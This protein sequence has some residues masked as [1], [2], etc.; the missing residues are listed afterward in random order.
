MIERR[1]RRTWYEISE[2]RNSDENPLRITEMINRVRPRQ[3]TFRFS[4]SSS[5]KVTLE[6]DC[7]PTVSDYDA[8]MLLD[9][10]LEEILFT[11]A[12]YLRQSDKY[13]VADTSKLLADRSD[14]NMLIFNDS[15]RDA[16][17]LLVLEG[18]CQT[19]TTPPEL[20][21]YNSIR[22]Y[23]LENTWL[24]SLPI[25][26]SKHHIRWI[27]FG[28]EKFI[29]PD[30]RYESKLGYHSHF[31]TKSS[32]YNEQGHHIGHVNFLTS[33]ALKEDEVYSIFGPL[34][35]KPPASLAGK[36]RG[37]HWIAEI[38]SQALEQA[39][40]RGD[41]QAELV[42][43]L[44][45]SLG[46]TIFLVV[47]SDAFRSYEQEVQRKQ[48]AEA[49]SRLRLRQE[50][51]QNADKVIFKGQP[52]MV[53][54]SN[55]NEVLALLCKLDALQALPF[56]KFLLWEYTA[57]VGI[58]A[59]ASYQIKEIDAPTPFAAVEL[60]HHFENFFDHGH[61][62]HQVNLVICWDFRDGEVPSEL[63][64][65]SGW[66]E[67]IFEYRNDESFVILALARIPDIQIGR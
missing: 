5:G 19:N 32:M 36:S 27:I 24:G 40:V 9:G 13:V 50:R 12:L 33:Q 7:E 39:V 23:L 2:H 65:R 11:D 1:M 34:T 52:L 28:E 26:N 22:S 58:D 21:N 20:Q 43:G 30:S 37:V 53:A 31:A 49:A 15:D 25:V 62:P 29:H 46:R 8:L 17:A 54:P 59:I 35:L 63:R 41:P 47:T 67:G 3:W 64:R 55:E 14:S 66:R 44:I 6:I 10:L 51:A 60:E 42:S 16:R 48:Q 57:R 18:F 56:H 61:P 45:H 4:F 38:S